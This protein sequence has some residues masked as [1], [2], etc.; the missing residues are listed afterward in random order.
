[1]QAVVTRAP[2]AAPTVP[3]V[4]SSQTLSAYTV[5]TFTPDVQKQVS[6]RATGHIQP[7]CQVQ[8]DLGTA[9]AVLVWLEHFSVVAIA[10]TCKYQHSLCACAVH[11]HSCQECGGSLRQ[12]SA[13]DD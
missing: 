1:M 2:S 8:P 4:S 13:S 12:C 3:A 11:C 10:N 5:D 7:Q 9:A 6:V